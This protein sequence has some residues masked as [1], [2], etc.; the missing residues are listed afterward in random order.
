[1]KNSRLGEDKNIEDNLIKDV[2]N[3]F[4][5]KKLKIKIKQIKIKQLNAEYLETLEIFLIM[6]KNVLIN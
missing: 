1:M 6:K 5:F 4:R 3:L 2:K